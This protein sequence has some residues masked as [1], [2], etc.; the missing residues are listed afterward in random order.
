MRTS[1]PQ[2]LDWGELLPAGC[3]FRDP[4]ELRQDFLLAEDQVFLVVNP[5]VVAGVFAEQ[6]PVAHLHVEQDSLTLFDLSSPD[7]NNLARTSGF[8]YL[9]QG[10][11]YNL[12]TMWQRHLSNLL[13]RS[14]T[15]LLAALSSSTLVVIVFSFMLPVLIF[16]AV[17]VY[18]IVDARAKKRPVTSADFKAAV[19]PTLIGGGITLISWFFLLSCSVAAT[20]YRDHQEFV[21]VNGALAGEKDRLLRENEDK[22]KRIKELED[23]LPRIIRQDGSQRQVNPGDEKKKRDVRTQLGLLRDEARATMRVCL[24]QPPV[25]QFSCEDAAMRWN[26]KTAK[27]IQENL[28]PSYLSKFTSATG[29]SISWTGTNDKTNNVLNFLNNHAAALEQFIKEQLN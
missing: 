14:W 19:I 4:A 9:T 24:A 21:S 12:V 25:P 5:D 11:A 6:N 1:T 27:Y 22:D 18:N 26:A 29:M 23:Q 20:I 2:P 10:R 13:S 7:S 15:N 17:I 16:I 28:E 8:E 3:C